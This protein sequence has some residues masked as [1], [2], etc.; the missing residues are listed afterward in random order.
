M[1]D[2]WIEEILLSPTAVA[3]PRSLPRARAV[4]GRGLAG[5]RYHAGTG[6]WSN[7]PVQTGTDLTLIEAEVLEAAGL[8]GPDARRNLVTRGIRLNELV[9]QEF[10]VGD[11]RLRGVELCE[12]CLGLGRAL[13]SARLPAANVVKWLSHRAGL[14]ADVLSSGVIARGAKITPAA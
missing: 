8:P 11:V 3:L 1:A 4:A 12:P 13:A 2:G 5:D 14:R 6:T 10:M 9:G 7:Y